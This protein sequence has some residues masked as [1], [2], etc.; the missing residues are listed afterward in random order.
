MTVPASL[1][2]K[3]RPMKA[4]SISLLLL[5]A[6]FSASADTVYP[7]VGTI[8][9]TGANV[10]ETID[11][12]FDFAWGG[13]DNGGIVSNMTLS[14]NGPLSFATPGNGDMG[15]DKYP[16]VPVVD[17]LG[18]DID[19]LNLSW[20]NGPYNQAPNLLA[21]VYSCVSATCAG[22]FSPVTCVYNCGRPETFLTSSFADPPVSTP[23]SSTLLLLTLGLGLAAAFKFVGGFGASVKHAPHGAGVGAPGAPPNQ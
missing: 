13:N 11:L 16:Y 14:D 22:D 21:S 1:G 9:L 15:L 2:A 8:T 17:G 4:L 12:S 7:F 20:F 5:F 19:V 23:E 3:Y 18:D 10:T 6:T